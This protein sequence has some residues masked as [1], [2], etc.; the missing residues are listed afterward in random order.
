MEV[1]CDEDR[2]RFSR[3]SA[4][5][6]RFG[7]SKD[8]PLLLV[9]VATTVRLG[10]VD[11]LWTVAIVL[12]VIVLGSVPFLVRGLRTHDLNEQAEA[13]SGTIFV[14]G[15]SLRV[16]QL[17]QPRFRVLGTGRRMGSIG[18]WIGARL[19]LTGDGL[20][21]KPGR[22]FG[23]GVPPFSVPWIEIDRLELTK[24][25]AKFDG[26]GLDLRMT[27]GSTL[28]I[29]VRGYERLSVALRQVS[30]P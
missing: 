29:E 12:N 25:P 14:G 24:L 2:R 11:H 17:G 15:C 23:G 3:R 5:L 28:A 30:L 13:P 16:G 27:D 20:T 9:A 26:G 18:G 8:D 4:A 1:G 6:A 21:V 22:H 19:L 7:S 10:V